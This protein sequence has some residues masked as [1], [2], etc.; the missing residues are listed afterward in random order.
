MKLAGREFS[1]SELELVRSLVR[2]FPG[3]AI[4]ELSMT[5][6]ELLEWRRPNGNLKSHESRQ[7]LERLE[8]D[9]DIKLPEVRGPDQRGKRRVVTVSERSRPGEEMV[10]S[11]G[12]FDFVMSRVTAGRGGDCGLWKE[13]IERYHYLGHR[14]AFGAT[15]RYLVR[16][17]SDPDRVMACLLW[18]SPAWKIAVRDRW[19]G[20][21]S[22]Q[23]EANLQMI[24]NN[25]RFL[26]LP[27]VKVKGLASRIL[28]R[29][30]RQ[31]PV[32]WE[33][34][35]GYRP[36]LLETMVDKSLYRGT[37]YLASNW[38]AL[39]ETRGRGRMDREHLNEGAAPKHVF[40][41]PLRRDA[42]ILLQREK[43]MI[44]ATGYSVSLTR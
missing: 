33:E 28:A 11:A 4:T 42:R 12:E 7:L 38:I 10:G 24:V 37:C 29:S 6:A 17:T 43:G 16:S 44:D 9:G 19:I 31:V 27:W 32:D 13:L 26:I 20:W 22:A 21:T 5:V 8:A 2:D 39:G 1:V 40:V 3:L 14:T 18:T 23:R 34:Q 41:Y 15:I 36:V 35:Y 30:A 25:G